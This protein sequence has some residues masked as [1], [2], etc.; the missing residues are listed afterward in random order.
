MSHAAARFAPK[1]QL[2][3]HLSSLQ[4]QLAAFANK[5]IAGACLDGSFDSQGRFLASFRSCADLT[6]LG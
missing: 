1:Q 6:F 2:T 5:G 3:V 4:G